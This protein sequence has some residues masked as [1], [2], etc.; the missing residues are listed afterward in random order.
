MHLLIV[1]LNAAKLL[2]GMCMLVFLCSYVLDIYFKCF[3][4]LDCLDKS[5][6]CELI[7]VCPLFLY[8]FRI[9]Y[10]HVRVV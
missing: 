7:H 2:L 6:H 3:F 1:V 8:M 4:E 5:P 10:M 9:M